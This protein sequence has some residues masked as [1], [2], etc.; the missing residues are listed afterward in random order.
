MQS[1]AD[2]RTWKQIQKPMQTLATQILRNFI[3]EMCV[4]ISQCF[5][6]FFFLLQMITAKLTILQN[7]TTK[8]NARVK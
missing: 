7:Q 1:I 2:G 5:W 3:L 4:L 6:I 8:I